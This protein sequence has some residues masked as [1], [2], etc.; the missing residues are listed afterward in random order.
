M[1][2]SRHRLVD[3]MVRRHIAPGYPRLVILLI[4]TGAGLAAFGFSALSLGFGLDD[5]ALRYFAATL[6]GYGAFLLLI[7]LWIALHRIRSEPGRD[8]VDVIDVGLRSP[9]GGDSFD[10]FGGGSSG[11]GGASASWGSGDAT[12]SSGIDLDVDADAGV[13]L[14]LAAALVLG[15]VLALAYV[16]YAAPIL[17]AEVALDAAIVTGLYRRL[18]KQDV[19]HWLGSA[20][21]RTWLPAT[22]AAVCFAFA[23]MA[24]EWA[25]PGA[26]SIGDVIRELNR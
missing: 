20:V 21:R 16:V 7:R 17:L 12:S 9:T 22:I 14:L 15:S 1:V 13:P 24:I 18:R 8:G 26:R 11:G 3:L 10:G 25:K 4:L 19:R 23:G 2:K 6:V 5:M